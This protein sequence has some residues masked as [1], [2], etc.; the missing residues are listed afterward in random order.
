MFRR[1]FAIKIISSPV[2]E[3]TRNK[4]SRNLINIIAISG[5]W[6]PFRPSSIFLCIHQLCKSY[7]IILI[8]FFYVYTGFR[9]D[10]F[11]S[12]FVIKFPKRL[13]AP[14]RMLHFPLI[15]SNL[16]FTLILSNEICKFIPSSLYN[17]IFTSSIYYL[18]SYNHCLPQTH[19]MLNKLNQLDVTLWK[20]FIAH[21]VS[22]VI[23]FILRS[24]R[25]YV[26]ALFC[27]GVYWRIGAVRLE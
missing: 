9:G 26:G 15:Y 24:W 18:K 20:F 21:H 1:Y 8:L 5:H 3:I 2:K 25:L 4:I 14:S 10:F 7:Y 16:I 17:N 27:F 13:S 19:W 6:N 12:D 22:N 23:T 11:S